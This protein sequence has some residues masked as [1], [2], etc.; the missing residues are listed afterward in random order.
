[1]VSLSNT[2]AF[3]PGAPSGN[4][5]PMHAKTQY[6]H[7]KL[8][9]GKKIGET[10]NEELRSLLGRLGIEGAHSEGAWYFLVTVVTVQRSGQYWIGGKLRW[11][12]TSSRRDRYRI[13]KLLAPNREPYA[14]SREV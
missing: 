5:G 10:S 12:T 13:S 1:M 4:S 8:P 2:K 7:L 6:D 9:S 14:A 3:I 11:R